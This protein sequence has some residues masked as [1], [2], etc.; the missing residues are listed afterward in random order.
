[1]FPANMTN[2]LPIGSKCR[3]YSPDKGLPMKTSDLYAMVVFRSTDSLSALGDSL[4]S[5]AKDLADS[6]VPWFPDLTIS[7]V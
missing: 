6:L 4:F 5:L 1:M 2:P 7:Q 3:L